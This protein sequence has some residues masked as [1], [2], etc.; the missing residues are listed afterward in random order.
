ML[1]LRTRGRIRGSVMGEWYT[2]QG[3]ISC[4]RGQ[5]ERLLLVDKCSARAVENVFK[6]E[7]DVARLEGVLG[8]DLRQKDFAIIIAGVKS[9]PERTSRSPSIRWRE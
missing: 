7:W 5:N 3:S 4:S 8:E 1:K 9:V 2:L 6:R